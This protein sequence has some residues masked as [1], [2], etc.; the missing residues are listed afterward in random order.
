MPEPV[1]AAKTVANTYA[2][3]RTEPWTY[4]T[5]AATD[6]ATLEQV[7]LT[8]TAPDFSQTEGYIYCGWNHEWVGAL[9]GRKFKKGFRRKNGGW[10]GYN[11]M[12]KQDGKGYRG[13]WKERRIGGKVH[14]MGFFRVGQ[15]ADEPPQKLYVPYQHCGTFNYSVRENTWLNFPFRIIRD[16]VVLPNPG[17]HEL[18][19]CKAYF[20]LGHKSLNLFY[21]YFLLGHR[22]PIELEAPWADER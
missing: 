12:C 8:G 22:R 20:Q 18:M 17:D 11:H 4:E 6:R 9:S 1:V 15:I 3:G 10:F 7:I 16:M 21:C 14:H 13:E 2:A 19:L 5:L